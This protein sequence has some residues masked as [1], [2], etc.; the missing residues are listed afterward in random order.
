M[1]GNGFHPPLTLRGRYLELVSLEKSHAPGLVVAGRDPE[2]WKLLRIGPGHPPSMV[3][4]ETFVDQL[5]AKQSAG[6]VLPLTM[7]LLPERTPVGV[8]RYL[9]IDRP[10]RMAEL[11]TWIDSR[12][13]RTP[14]NTEAKWL[15][16]RYAF[17]E[18]GVHRLQLKTDSRNDRSRV[19]IERL[20]ALP[21]GALREAHLV[22]G[23][24][25]RTSLYYSILASEWPA[26]KRRLEEKLSRPWERR[27]PS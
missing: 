12:Y 11:G 13:W 2:V 1:T 21:E 7:L 19:A 27:A 20:G 17:E 14:L 16:L 23:G 26:V 22:Q 9:D 15:T 18:E 6:E 3:E 8:I 24:F 25:Y 5:L 4:M 10:N